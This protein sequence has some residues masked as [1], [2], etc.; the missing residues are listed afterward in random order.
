MKVL[1]DPIKF[2]KVQNN[3]QTKSFKIIKNI[4]KIHKNKSK[5][6]ILNIKKTLKIKATEHTYSNKQELLLLITRYK[7]SATVT[8]IR[9]AL[10]KWAIK[11]VNKKA[12]LLKSVSNRF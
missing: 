12:R 4:L 10:R 11:D 9:S 8:A 6:Q 7:R 1:S 5:N 2:A 3:I